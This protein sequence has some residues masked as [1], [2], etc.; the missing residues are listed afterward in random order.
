MMKMKTAKETTG[1]SQMN[2]GSAGGGGELEVRPGGMLVQKRDPDSDRTS[3]PPPTIRIKVKYGSTNHEINISSQATFG[4]LKKMLSAPTGLHHQD[5]KLIYKAKERDSKAF[6]DISGVKDRSKM[7]LVEDPISQEKRFLEMRKNAKMEKASK[8]ISE[9][10]LDVDR[11]AGQVSAFESV[12][13]KGGKVA[14]KS[15]LNLIELLMNQLVKLDGILVDGDAKLQ[16][17]IQVKRVQKYVETLDM[18]KMKN[19]MPNGNAA[20]EVKDSMPNGNGHHAPMQQQQKHSNGQKVASI[21]KRQPRSSNGHALIPIEEGEE[22]RHSFEHFSF[23]Q[24]PQP[25]PRRSASGEVIVTT[26]W[27]TFD[28]TPA[29]EPAPSASTFSTATKTP[30]HQPKF[31]WDLFN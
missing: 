30:A 25:S 20:D 4:E 13:T 9:I 17:K 21:Q 6:L 3:V 8:S 7:V 31:P 18:L 2:G 14:E 29:S 28:S 11:L 19:S 1:L 22:P 24:P 12:I 26:Q 27:E 5:Q 23:H 10:S 16:R 15:V